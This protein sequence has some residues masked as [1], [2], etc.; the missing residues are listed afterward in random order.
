MQQN[1]MMVAAI[2]MLLLCIIAM[3]SIMAQDRRNAELDR[4]IA[5]YGQQAD[6]MKELSKSADELK[7]ELKGVYDSMTAYDKKR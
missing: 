7:K 6:K 4:Q 1:N 3:G 5:Y 2:T